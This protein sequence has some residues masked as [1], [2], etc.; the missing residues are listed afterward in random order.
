MG[1]V[2]D[3]SNFLTSLT[4]S[5]IAASVSIALIATIYWLVW[6]PRIKKTTRELSSLKAYFDQQKTVGRQTIADAISRTRNENIKAVLQEIQSGLFDLPGDFGVKTYS[7]RFY[8]DIM[9]P[10]ALLSKRVNMSLFDAAPNILIGIGLLFT[11]GFLAFALADVIPAF[12]SSA[13]TESVRNAIEGLLR[14]A[15]GKFLTSISGMFCS[16][17]WTFGSKRSIE[18][19]ENEIE[20]LCV[21]MQ[22]HIEDT[23]SEAAISAQIGIMNE[24]LNESREQ[25]GQLRRFETD[26]AVAISKAFSNQMQPAF[27]KLSTS[28]TDALNAL[29]EKVGSMNEDAL[30]KMLDDFQSAIREHSSLEMDQFKK[31][32]LEVS[33]QIKSAAVTLEGAGGNAGAAIKDGGKEFTESLSS[34]A[35]DLRQAAGLLEEAMV[36][37][38]A[39]VND[40]DE[41]LE[42]A[43]TDGQQGL[44]NLKESLALLSLTTSRIGKLVETLQDASSDLNAAADSAAK[45]AGNLDNVLI[46]Q[47]KLTSKISDSALTLG[48]AVTTVNKE[49]QLSAQTMAD[50]TVKMTAGV[51]NYSQKLSALHNSLDQNLSKAIGSLNSATQE[52]NDNLED[53]LE[54]LGK[55]RN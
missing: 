44:E 47:N 34:G 48:A 55:V 4:P 53:F 2:V 28:I 7:L 37:A 6:N 12:T 52:L 5:V 19:L 21:S 40:L 17:L 10:R 46:E 41:T 18:S 43:A 35:N 49:F 38:K 42:R 13:Q 30:K 20:A 32:L 24:I 15:A 50:T 26:F 27:E 45:V 16:L 1:T 29:T 3:F 8:Q 25:V 54:Q 33:E 22:R 9:T 51:E 36:S 31:S 23:G 14:N 39:T 11:F